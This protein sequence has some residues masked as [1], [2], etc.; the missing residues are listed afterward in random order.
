MMFTIG[1]SVAK[2]FQSAENAYRCFR[3]INHS[4][5]STAMVRELA[6]LT[7]DASK[8]LYWLFMSFLHQ[9]KPFDIFQLAERFEVKNCAKCSQ[10]FFHCDLYN[11]PSVV[12][13]PLHPGESLTV[14]CPMCGTN[15]FDGFGTTQTKRCDICGT[16][17]SP[18]LSKRDEI[19][20]IKE[21][22]T[23][24]LQWASEL[25]PSWVKFESDRDDPSLRILNWAIKSNHRTPLNFLESS[26]PVSLVKSNFWMEGHEALHSVFGNDFRP[27]LLSHIRPEYSE[28]IRSTCVVY[29]IAELTFPTSPV[30][31]GKKEQLIW[32]HSLRNR[33]P[34]KLEAPAWLEASFNKATQH[35]KNFIIEMGLCECNDNPTSEKCGVCKLYVR[36]KNAVSLDGEFRSDRNYGRVPRPYTFVVNQIGS[37][38]SDWEIYRIADEL[39]KLLFQKELCASFLIRHQTLRGSPLRAFAP[40]TLENEFLATNLNCNFIFWLDADKLLHVMYPRYLSGIKLIPS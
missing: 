19:D 9:K 1:T 30:S 29:P 5:D 36:W 37:Q 13:C 26:T 40:F 32:E 14:K 6:E 11:L 33:F 34:R 8:K 2:P 25:Y 15:W 24:L 35:V 38:P 4:L 27:S 21:K 22:L 18:P 12:Q 3:A 23:P 17:R 28:S 20:F 39:Q 16:T 10:E 31:R 7:G